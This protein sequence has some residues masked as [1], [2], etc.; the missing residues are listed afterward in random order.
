MFRGSILRF[1]SAAAPTAETTVLP[2]G[3]RVVSIDNG[4]PL[5]TLGVLLQAGARHENCSTVGASHYL[6]R[7]ATFSTFNRSSVRL[8]NQ[9]ENV[10][11]FQVQAGRETTAFS[12]QALRSEAPSAAALL[13]DMLRPR[14][15]EYEIRDVADAVAADTEEAL[16][17]PSLYLEDEV[18]STAFRARGL[19]R[20]LYARSTL[21][22]EQ[23]LKFLYA[24]WRAEFT[25]LVGLNVPHAQLVEAASAQGVLKDHVEGFSTPRTVKP[26]DYQGGESRKYSSDSVRFAIGFRGLS[27]C[28]GGKDVQA[29]LVRLLSKRLGSQWTASSFTAT[30]AGLVTLTSS[31][32]LASGS[33]AVVDSGILSLKGP[34]FTQAEV[35]LAKKA[36]AAQAGVCLE[37]YPLAALRAV[38]CGLPNVSAVTA[39]QVGMGFVL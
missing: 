15:L 25:T 18:H 20:S 28:E 5:A 14:V 27:H 2:N 35:D 38:S 33:D 6:S 3:L 39:E 29:V 16:A 17:T 8:T 37:S 26:A 9:L 22:Q 30:D 1:Y 13:L 21:T 11:S 7:L 12:L 4:A 32:D 19:G 24:N 34:A 23:V 36:V 31:S 10:H